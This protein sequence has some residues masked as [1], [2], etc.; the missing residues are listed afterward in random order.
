MIYFL[1]KTLS[2]GNQKLLHNTWNYYFIYITWNYYFI[3]IFGLGVVMFSLAVRVWRRG[4][5]AGEGVGIVLDKCDCE[6]VQWLRFLHVYTFIGCHWVKDC[7]TNFNNYVVELHISEKHGVWMIV[8]YDAEFNGKCYN[9]GYV[10]LSENIFFWFGLGRCVRRGC[11]GLELG[12]LW[13]RLSAVQD[14]YVWILW[15]EVKLVW[16]KIYSI[17]SLYMWLSGW[18]LIHVRY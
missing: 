9:W 11:D 15:F 13:G 12:A 6:T 7:I 1:H 17:L 4:R 16:E 3:F 5:F 14:I 8:N 18:L 2:S 10:E